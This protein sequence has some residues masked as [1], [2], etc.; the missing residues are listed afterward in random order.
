MS[1]HEDDNDAL[2]V[3]DVLARFPIGK[4]KLFEEIR[5]G[6]LKA[7]MLGTRIVIL[8][9]H[10]DEWVASLPPHARVGNR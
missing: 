10:Y 8:R 3:K 9:R 6:R 4:T 5:A 7:R 2:S 1:E